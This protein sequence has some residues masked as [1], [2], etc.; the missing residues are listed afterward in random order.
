MAYTADRIARAMG[1]TLVAPIVTYVPEGSWETASGHMG[2]PGTITLPEDRFI[3][4]LVHAGRSLKAGGFT[5]IYFLGES[6]GN[7]TGMRAAAERLNGM[8]QGAARAYWVD[9]YYTK[10]HREQDVLAAKFLGVKPG[11]VGGHA[12][13]LDTSELM[14]VAP[15]HVRMD[16]LS[17]TTTRT[18]ASAAT[19]R[20]RRRPTTAASSSRSRSTTRWRRSS[21]W[22]AAPSRRCR[23]RRPPAGARRQPPAPPPGRPRPTFETAPAGL[24]PT[25][26][27]DTVF[28][29]ELTWEETRDALKAGTH[30]HRADWRHRE[31]R[32]PHGARQAQFRR[33]AGRR[34]DGA[35]P[36]HTL[37][38]PVIA[39][40]PEG[41]PD[42]QVP[43]A[44]SLPSPAYDGLLDA[45][46]RSLQVHGFTE[47]L[48]I[49]DSG[50]NQ[51]GMR[52]VAEQLNAEWKDAGARVYALTDYYE[53]GAST[54]APG[55]SPPSATTTRS[56]AAT[57][58]QRHV[59]DAVRP[60]AGHPHGSDLAL[61]RPQDSGVTGD[62]TRS[63]A[64]I[65]RMGW[66]R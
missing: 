18:T 57:P 43:G 32:L 21:G 27:P 6:G 59:A 5:N 36:R 52:A 39:Y 11:E 7:R 56:S 46:A 42:R 12:N 24:T 44:I 49:G 33:P 37:V 53:G 58:H 62:P 29:D 31:E 61:G 48:F 17:A 41:D 47:I 19:T 65:G 34:D 1:R 66:V 54:I 23:R 25:R 26:A 38:A 4:L 2:K 28:I 45:A 14:F 60:P 16:R 64:D 20:R 40:V 50:G 9:D 55:C 3:E 30:G 13:I 63:T 35:A 8:W 51:A 10:A 15:Q 22:R